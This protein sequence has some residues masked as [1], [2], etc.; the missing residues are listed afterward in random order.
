MRGGKT[1]SIWLNGI[2]SFELLILLWL[3][4]FLLKLLSKNRNIFQKDKNKNKCKN[5][6]FYLK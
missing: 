6:A 1:S 4:Y 2:S 5:C 3:G